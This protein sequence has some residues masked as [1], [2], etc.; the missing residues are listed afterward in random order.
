LSTDLDQV[1]IGRGCEIYCLLQKSSATQEHNMWRTEN[2]V[3][4]TYRS[5]TSVIHI[6]RLGRSM[7]F[8]SSH[9]L[10]SCVTL[11]FFN[12]VVGVVWKRKFSFMFYF[13]IPFRWKKTYLKVRK[14]GKFLRKLSHKRQFSRNEI[15]RNVHILA[16]F[17]DFRKKIL[18]SLLVSKLV[19]ESRFSFFPNQHQIDARTPKDNIQ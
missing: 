17:A 19:G 11:V 10:C 4:H 13:I 15:S 5:E 8:S 3:I 9:M 14:K 16:Y 18:K 7:E 6:S 12:S 1:C 2:C